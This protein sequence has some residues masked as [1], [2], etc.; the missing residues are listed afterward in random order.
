[1]IETFSFGRIPDIHFGQGKLTMIPNLISGFGQK[2]IVIT[3]STIFLESAQWEVLSELLRLHEFEFYHHVVGQQPTPE[4][5]DNITEAHRG[6]GIEAVLAIGGGSVLDAGKAVAAMLVQ[7]GSV[8]EY[9]DQIGTKPNTGKTLPLIAVPTTAG[10]GSETTKYAYI[11]EMGENGFKKAFH[12]SHYVPKIAIIDPELAV[13]CAPD[14]TAFTGLNAFSQLMSAYVSIDANQLTDT[15]SYKGLAYIKESLK[16]AYL[17]G[18]NIKARS[19]LAYASMV[20]GIVSTNTGFGVVKGLSEAVGQF[21]DI[22]HSL[23][24]ATLLPAAV[25]KT[26]YEVNK[27]YGNDHYCLEKY[28]NIG[29]LFNK[30]RGKSQSY[31]IEALI[32]K[33]YRWSAIFNVPTLFD[34]GV[35][36]SDLP[37]I[38]EATQFYNNPMPILAEE[39]I[40][41]LKRRF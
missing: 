28:A 23:I 31:Y 36:A 3:G 12:H 6:E 14:F 17:D 18:G 40:T 1:M 41:I 7:P 21:Y 22:P 29:R 39:A 35:Q 16:V 33:L 20:S 13:S 25:E 30:R 5:I 37:R 10:T 9:I 38:A 24:T 4:I 19:N 27:Y 2:I 8:R 11:S 34:L 26:V 32:D 15:L